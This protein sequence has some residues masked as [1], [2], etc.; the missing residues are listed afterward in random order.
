MG[1]CC[2]S[3]VQDSKFTQNPKKKKKSMCHLFLCT[4]PCKGVVAFLDI[5][6]VDFFHSFFDIFITVFFRSAFTLSPSIPFSQHL[7]NLL[8]HNLLRKG[9]NSNS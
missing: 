5:F 2:L 4:L 8:D 7:M 1:Q 9:L 6:I 3:R